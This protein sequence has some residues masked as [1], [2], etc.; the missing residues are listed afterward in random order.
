MGPGLASRYPEEAG[1]PVKAA[2]TRDFEALALLARTVSHGCWLSAPGLLESEGTRE[3]CLE[4]DKAVT[5]SVLY[6]PTG[7][8]YRGLSVT[9]GQECCC[10]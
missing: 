6:K 5:E 3:T 10:G 2:C 9:S 4:G 7:V 8:V 1:S